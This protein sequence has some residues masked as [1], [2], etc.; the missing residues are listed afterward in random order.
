[1]FGSV[2]VVCERQV[3]TLE[4]FTQTFSGPCSLLCKCHFFL[5]FFFV[6]FFFF[7][8]VFTVF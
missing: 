7:Q 6:L 2:Y 1:M 3:D 8:F 4:A 5:G